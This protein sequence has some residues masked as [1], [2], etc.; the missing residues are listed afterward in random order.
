MCSLLLDLDQVGRDDGHKMDFRQLMWNQSSVL[1][2]GMKMSVR[3]MNFKKSSEEALW[4]WMWGSGGVGGRWGWEASKR[5]KTRRQRPSV[6][7][8][9]CFSPPSRPEKIN[10]FSPLSSCLA[11]FFLRRLS[12][13]EL[14]AF[15]CAATARK[16]TRKQPCGGAAASN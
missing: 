6:R 2:L 4:W 14:L 16:E 15:T 5:M 10:S 3:L 9:R 7:P 11:T 1:S 8:S 13:D 12:A